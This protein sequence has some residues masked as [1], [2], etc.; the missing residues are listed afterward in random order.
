MILPLSPS[1][2]P[3]ARRLLQESGLAG[4]MFPQFG[5]GAIVSSS[6]FNMPSMKTGSAS[7]GSMSGSAI[8]VTV[9]AGLGANGP[10]IAEAVV[11]E[12]KKWEMRNGPIPVR[13][14]GST[15]ATTASRFG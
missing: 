5:T 10:L 7:A 4:E 9:N 15:T 11:S 1:K 12:L 3:F 8:S 2:R 6:R 14:S 13:V